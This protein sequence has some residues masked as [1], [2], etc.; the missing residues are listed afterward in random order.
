MKGLKLRNIVCLLFIC[1]IILSCGALQQP[2]PGSLWGNWTFIKIGSII[3]DANERLYDYR[4][5]CYKESDRIHF[6]SD[7]KLTLRWYDDSCD[8]HYS[9]I[10]KYQVENTILKVSLENR[11]AYQ[12]RPLPPITEYR[13]LQINSTTL[14]LEEIRDNYIPKRDEVNR[15]NE[16]R[17][18]VFMKME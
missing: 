6:S 2:L 15:G 18:F 9:L 8:I 5:A 13:I 10:G 4:N 16:A 14:K 11:S 1:N 7:K 12:D 3:N 17:V